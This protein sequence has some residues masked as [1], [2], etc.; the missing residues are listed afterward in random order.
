M[1]GR[2]LRALRLAAGWTQEQ[3]AAPG[4]VARPV[5]AMYEHGRACIGPKKVER[6]ARALTLAAHER[7]ATKTFHEVGREVVGLIANGGI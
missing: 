4:P 7:Q 1:T 2:E 3:A 5:L 6:I